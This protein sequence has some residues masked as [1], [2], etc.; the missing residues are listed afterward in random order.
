ME[1]INPDIFSQPLPV[2]DPKPVDLR[3]RDEQG[4][5]IK[6]TREPRHYKNGPKPL[7]DPM[8]GLSYR[9]NRGG[10]ADPNQKFFKC[11]VCGRPDCEV[12]NRGYVPKYCPDCLRTYRH[13]MLEEGR[14]RRKAKEIIKADKKIPM[15]DGSIGYLRDKEEKDYITH[16][17]SVYTKEY[18]WSQSS[19]MGLLTK[20]VFLELQTARLA[21]LLTVTYSAKDAKVMSDLTEEYRKCQVD[22]GINRTQRLNEHTEA[23]APSIVRELMDKFTAYKEKH[24]ERFMWKCQH[25]GQI[26]GLNKQNPAVPVEETPLLPEDAQPEK[27]SVP[28]EAVPEQVANNA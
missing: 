25:C 5:L 19:D 27:E 3:P 28:A 26:N 4:H 13:Q 15:P 2:K 24:P 16:R 6:P 21:K 14:A 17:L 11:T 1:D 23:D 8:A 22:L 7:P 9:P 20:L 12:T 10:T 18:E